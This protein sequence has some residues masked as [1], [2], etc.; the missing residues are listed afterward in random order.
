M[1][2]QPP[3]D[4]ELDTYI[5]ARLAGIGIDLDQLDP[6]ERDPDTGSPSQESVLSSIRQL[7]RETVPAISDW[8][9]PVADDA[10]DAGDDVHRLAQQAPPP[11]LYPSITTGTT[12]WTG[13]GEEDSAE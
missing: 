7:L 8:E 13:Q 9:P 5:R 10:G 11:L 2:V 1:S 3:T 6:D 12:G 4:A